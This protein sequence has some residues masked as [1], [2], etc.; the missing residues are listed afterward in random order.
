MFID[1]ARSQVGYAQ[2]SCGGEEPRNCGEK[3]RAPLK[4]AEE[5][6]PSAYWTMSWQ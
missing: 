4:L 6:G 2:V 3:V 1:A 5:V